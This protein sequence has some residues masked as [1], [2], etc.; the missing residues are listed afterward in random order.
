MNEEKR[1]TA[2]G[3]EESVCG[4]QSGR[5]QSTHT[6]GK[7]K[8]EKATD[9]RAQPLQIMNFL[10]TQGEVKGILYLL[11][12]MLLNHVRHTVSYNKA[13]QI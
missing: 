5:S 3:E 4:S 2:C 9:P 12:V 8:D 10:Q 1:K 11:T 7:I 6:G 13:L